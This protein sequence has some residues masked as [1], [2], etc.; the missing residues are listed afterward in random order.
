M[1]NPELSTGVFAILFVRPGFMQPLYN[2][3]DDTEVASFCAAVQRRYCS[4][5]DVCIGS[6][7]PLT[8]SPRDDLY[9]EELNGTI[10]R[11]EKSAKARLTA[12]N[13]TVP[14]AMAVYDKCLAEQEAAKA[15]VNVAIC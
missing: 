12:P 15:A 10:K 14:E 11:A 3:A 6:C 5:A 2:L 1:V 4:M 13:S 8:K 9:D 7:C